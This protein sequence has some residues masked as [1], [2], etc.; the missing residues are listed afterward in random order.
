MFGIKKVFDGYQI[1][2]VEQREFYVHKDNYNNLPLS[3]HKLFYNE[4]VKWTN[5][6]FKYRSGAKNRIT[7]LLHLVIAY[8]NGTVKCW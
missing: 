5:K 4:V 7:K 8:M 1:Y 2:I 6:T 3:N